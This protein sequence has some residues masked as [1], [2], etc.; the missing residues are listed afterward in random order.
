MLIVW[1]QR[2][3]FGMKNK[4]NMSKHDAVFSFFSLTVGLLV[5]GAA[6]LLAGCATHDARTHLESVAKDWCETIRASQVIP[7]YPLTQ[8]VAIGDVFLVQTPIANQA[9]DY[10]KR[11]F[12]A[13]DDFRVRLPYTNFHKVYFDGYWKD[14]FGNT[15]HPMPEFTNVVTGSNATTGSWTSVDAP[16]VAFPTYSF[17]AKSGF[18]LSAAFPIQGVPV[19]LGFLRTD[20]VNGS[21]TITDARTFA[22]DQGDLFSQLNDWADSPK[23]KSMLSETVRNIAPTPVYL[24]VVSRIY[25]ARAM[26]VSLQKAG[27][28][29]ANAR[30]GTATSLSMTTTN[31]TVSENYSNLLSTLNAQNGVLA[32]ATQAGGSVTFVSASDSSVGLSQSFDRLLVVGYLGFDVPVYRGGDL[33]E[34]IPTFQHLQG[35]LKEAP[36]GV[37]PLSQDQTRFSAYQLALESLAVSDPGRA[38]R[39]MRGIAN[40]LGGLEFVQVSTVLASNNP[41]NPDPAP[42]LTLVKQ[43]KLASVNYVSV[44][45]NTGPRYLR[46]EDAFTR[47][48]SDSEKITD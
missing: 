3:K 18:G 4:R 33:G 48:F 2:Q 36:D 23:V 19:A 25:A 26:D 30:G 21:I 39:L 17:Q 15:P 14:I 6:L 16:R 22:G 24:R 34:P 40:T 45:G 9:K 7:V 28:Q 38:L 27:S 43:F 13:L 47:A 8:D 29:G 32:S 35:R 42:V 31:G 12:L 41:A 10:Q 1:S 37:G 46:Y 44:S 5:F 20:Q 11:G